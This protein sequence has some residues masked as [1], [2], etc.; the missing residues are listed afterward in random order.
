MGCGGLWSWDCR[1][2]IFNAK[3]AK[4]SKGFKTER[5]GDERREGNEETDGMGWKRR[6]ALLPLQ[7]YPTCPSERL[8][9][10]SLCVPRL[11]LRTLRSAFGLCS[12]QAVSTRRSRRGWGAVDCGHGIVGKAFSTRRSRR[13]R[14]DS[15]RNAE[16]TSGGK[17]T[18][19]QTGWGGRGDRL[20]CPCNRIR[21]VLLSV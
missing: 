13:T 12:L 19:K 4:N 14:R 17:G 15:R 1:K 21:P 3:V 11:P 8:T 20:S 2:R 9:L 5:R 18:R 7:P 6:S 16:G 10:F